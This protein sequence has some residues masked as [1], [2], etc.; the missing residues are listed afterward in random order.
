[1]ENEEEGKKREREEEEGEEKKGREEGNGESRTR[2]VVR[3]ENANLREYK[4]E[5]KRSSRRKLEDLSREKARGEGK[6]RRQRLYYGCKD[7][8]MN[9]RC[10]AVIINKMTEKY[11]LIHVNAYIL[12]R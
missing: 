12:E 3:E 5:E 8:Q 1:M 4:K 11:T 9:R 10:E 6:Y 2:K 7:V